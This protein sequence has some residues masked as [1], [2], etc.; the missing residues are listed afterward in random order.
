MI[1]RADVGPMDLVRSSS[2]RHPILIGGHVP[3][4]L[5]LLVMRAARIGLAA[6]L[7]CQPLPGGEPD[8]IRKPVIHVACPG[9]C[10][11]LRQLLQRQQN[12]KNER[13]E[14]DPARQ[15]TRLARTKCEIAQKRQR[16][17]QPD[18]ADLVTVGNGADERPPSVALA[19]IGDH[20]DADHEPDKSQG[21]G[22][23]EVAS[24][25]RTN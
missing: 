1:A 11:C 9:G 2:H 8:E 18:V 5:V 16:A 23:P 21:G 17:D 4:L 19:T 10:E 12:Q 6:Q 20:D 15:K 22:N 14:S 7:E 13:R 24:H 25:L 3:P